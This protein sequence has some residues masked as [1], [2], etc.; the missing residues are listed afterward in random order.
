MVMCAAPLGSLLI[1]AVERERVK[2][3]RQYIGKGWRFIVVGALRLSP[4]T[5]H[6]RQRLQ[7]LGTSAHTG[8]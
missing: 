6:L 7:G 8:R 5:M 1:G 3:C 2:S 4:E